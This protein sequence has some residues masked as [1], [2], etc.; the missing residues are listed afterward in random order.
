MYYGG[1]SDHSVLGRNPRSSADGPGEPLA[2]SQMAAIV[3]AG[4]DA[5]RR[6]LAMVRA[7]PGGGARRRAGTFSC[8]PGS[9]FGCRHRYRPVC[10]TQA[11]FPA[12]TAVY[13]RTALLG[14]SAAPGSIL[15]PLGHTITAFAV[16]AALAGYYPELLPGLLFCAV[17]IAASRVVLGMHFLSDV[18]AGAAL[19]TTLGAVAA[20][21][22]A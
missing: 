10:G 3:D 11:R 9:Q 4:R 6:W 17:S 1:S 7:R 14:A 5:L 18:L 20:A 2:A 13:A 19:G 12:S 8:P 22:V 21:L 16:T 15:I